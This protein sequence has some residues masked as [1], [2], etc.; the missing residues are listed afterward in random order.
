MDKTLVYPRFNQI[1]AVSHGVFNSLSHYLHP[2]KPSITIIPNTISDSFS[3]NSSDIQSFIH[4]RLKTLD[5]PT[6]VMTARFS[7][8]KYQSQLIK[9][10]TLSNSFRLVLIG[11]GPCL[12]SSVNFSKKLGV[13]D[14]VRFTGA[15]TQYDVIKILKESTFYIHSSHTEAFGIAA[16]EAMALGIPTFVSSIPGLSEISAE[17][18]FTFSNNDILTL[19]ERLSSLTRSPSQYFAYAMRCYQHSCQYSPIK[20]ASLVKNFYSELSKSTSS[21]NNF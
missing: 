2:S 16:L 11:D 1:I 6:I 3:F 13:E 12:A 5:N 21:N 10:L 8:H 9:L 18:F 20:I 7:Y 4:L 19:Q 14:R 17:P 15:L